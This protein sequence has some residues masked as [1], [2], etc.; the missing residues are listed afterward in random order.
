VTN[1]PRQVCF[2]AE[3]HFDSS[4][5]AVE[6]VRPESSSELRKRGITG[7]L[8]FYVAPTEL[9]RVSNVAITTNMP[10]LRSCVK[11]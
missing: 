7:A 8:E 6:D 1:V 3:R 10:L 5:G 9:E 4:V 11:A 2:D